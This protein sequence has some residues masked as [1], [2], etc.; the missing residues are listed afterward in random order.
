MWLQ[1]GAFGRFGISSR[2]IGTG[3]IE[4]QWLRLTEQMQCTNLPEINRY[5][6]REYRP[7]WEV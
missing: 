7:G 1:A 2:R 4:T 3:E 6:R 5:V